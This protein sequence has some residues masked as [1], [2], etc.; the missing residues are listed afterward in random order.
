M[1]QPRA[2]GVDGLHLEPARRFQCQREQPPRQRA[3]RRVRPDARNPSDGRVEL[4]IVERGPAPQ[5]V[6]HAIRHV[7]RG[8]L[9]EGDAEDLGRI[10]AVEQ[11]PNHPL[12][13]D[14]GLA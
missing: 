7:G 8:G 10:D 14:V 2:E 6:E 12:R 5:L 1:Q 11:E 4:R 13:Q 9:G 3:P